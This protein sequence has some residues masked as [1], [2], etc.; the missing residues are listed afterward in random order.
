MLLQ[1]GE[2]QEALDLHLEIMSSRLKKYGRYSQ[3]T[4]TSKYSLGAMYHH[5][6]DLAIA[7]Y[8]SYISVFNS[9]M[10]GYPHACAQPAN[11]HLHRDYM[12][13]CVDDSAISANCAENTVARARY[14]LA[15]LYREQN[16]ETTEVTE[17]EQKALETLRLYHP[18]S[19]DGDDDSVMV[20]FDD[21]QSVP[22]GRFTGLNLLRHLQKLSKN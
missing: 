5:R 11:F 19:E 21:L 14:H 4:I 3:S 2:Q 12:K 22:E 8:V 17:L 15:K 20:L 18:I 16:S 10:Y 1:A 7:T 9:A 6:G 13:E